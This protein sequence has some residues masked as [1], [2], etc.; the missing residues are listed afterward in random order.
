[1]YILIVLFVTSER[2]VHEITVNGLLEKIK[3]EI[4]VEQGF[5]WWLLDVICCI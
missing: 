1:M 3:E 2:A 5:G 4:K